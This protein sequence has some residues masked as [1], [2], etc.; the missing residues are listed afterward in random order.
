MPADQ[1]NVAQPPALSVSTPVIAPRRRRTPRARPTVLDALARHGEIN[2]C[3][4]IHAAP[5][6]RWPEPSGYLAACA[7]SRKF[8]DLLPLRVE[9]LYQRLA[10]LLPHD[11]SAR[12]FPL[13]KIQELAGNVSA[14]TARGLINILTLSGTIPLIEHQ[15]GRPGVAGAYRFVTRPLELLNRQHMERAGTI[16]RRE[17]LRADRLRRRAAGSTA[18]A[19][20][21]TRFNVEWRLRR[22]ATAGESAALA[23]A[24][25]VRATTTAAI[26]YRTASQLRARWGDWSSFAWER[27]TPA[28]FD[29]AGVSVTVRREPPLIG[30]GQSFA[31]AKAAALAHLQQLRGAL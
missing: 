3:L 12:R 25:P 31:D 4:E 14:R 24:F 16:K 29:R 22:T 7:L 2:K 19:V 1:K 9:R 8:P 17:E 18:A 26:E 20:T 11:G 6:R 5:T 21:R 15:P 30:S 10:G 23:L 28:K 27:W 13:K